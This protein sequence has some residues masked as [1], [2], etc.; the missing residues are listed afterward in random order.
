MLQIDLVA[1]TDENR[2]FQIRSSQI[3]NQV[4]HIVCHLDE[5]L[6]L[7]KDLEDAEYNLFFHMYAKSLF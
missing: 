7:I 5:T 2:G 4:L 1:Y 6:N 3:R